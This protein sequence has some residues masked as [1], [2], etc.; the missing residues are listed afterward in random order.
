LLGYDSCLL[1]F[2]GYFQRDR[3]SGSPLLYVQV[4]GDRVGETVRR[5]GLSYVGVSRYRS[6]AYPNEGACSNI[7]QLLALGQVKPAEK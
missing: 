5:D 2:D 4:W 3:L 6:T 1:W 7:E